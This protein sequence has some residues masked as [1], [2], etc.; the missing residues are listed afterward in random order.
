MCVLIVGITIAMLS[1][2]LLWQVNTALPRHYIRLWRVVPAV[3]L[4]IIQ[5]VA[6]GSWGIT[7]KTTAV[8]VATSRGTITVLSIRT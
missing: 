3:H 6:T 7:V 5:D 2:R 1:V 8:T 4:T